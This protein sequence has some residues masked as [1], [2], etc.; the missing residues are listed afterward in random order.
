MALVEK[1]VQNSGRDAFP[2]FFRRQRVAKP[3]DPLGKFDSTKLGSLT[4]VEDKN[5]I[6]YSDSDVRIG[7]VLNLFGRKIKIHSYDAFTQNYLASVHGVKDHTPIEGATPP[8]FIPPC[9]QRR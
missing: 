8:P 1:E 3:T 9:A 2:T 6:Y 5:T 7:N 4:F